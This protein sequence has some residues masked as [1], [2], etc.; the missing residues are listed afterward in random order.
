MIAVQQKLGAAAGR[1][2]PVGH[3]GDGGLVRPGALDRH[4]AHRV[5]S[6]AGEFLEG[7][8]LEPQHPVRDLA[9]P[10]VVADD[11]DAAP[12]MIGEVAQ[13]PGDV[14]AMRGVEVGGGFVGK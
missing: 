7:T 3:I 12:V 10:I 9:E 2:E 13:Q 5:H 4:A 8:V 14:A 11:D 1:A 6:A